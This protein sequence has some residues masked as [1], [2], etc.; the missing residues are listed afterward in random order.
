MS[1]NRD[2]TGRLIG[3][4]PVPQAQHE[5]C[6]GDYPKWVQPHADHIVRKEGARPVAPA[7]GEQAVDRNGV[8]SVCVANED[9]E[10]RATSPKP[11]EDPVPSPR[12][13]RGRKAPDIDAP[14][15]DPL[16][17]LDRAEDE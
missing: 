13:G 3:I 11:A 16:G 14:G 15:G 7:F 6:G 2:E 8:L 12:R 17:G 10:A 1:L 5:A 4:E 9:E